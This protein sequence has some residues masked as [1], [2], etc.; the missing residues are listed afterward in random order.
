MGPGGRKERAY[1]CRL[2]GR[3]RI[4]GSSREKQV[5][6]GWWG[7]RD[8]CKADRRRGT[9]YETNSWN[10]GEE[11]ARE[12]ARGKQLDRVASNAEWQGAARRRMLRRGG[13]RGR[14]RWRWGKIGKDRPTEEA[15]ARQREGRRRERDWMA[16]REGDGGAYSRE[17]A[18]VVFLGWLGEIRTRQT[19]GLTKVPEVGILSLAATCYTSA[20]PEPAGGPASLR[21][22]PLLRSRIIS[23]RS[24]RL[25]VC[26]SVGL[27]PSDGNRRKSTSRE[28]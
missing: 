21:R 24:S 26:P 17:K 6:A 28:T 12:R 11:R 25:S 19:N 22:R 27:S 7:K 13:S 10:D 9:K 20:R 8:E 14:R 1:V 4:V 2:F 16:R 15:R 3:G 23:T 18:A 5:V